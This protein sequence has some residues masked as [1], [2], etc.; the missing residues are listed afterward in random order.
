ML[1]QALV[2]ELKSAPLLRSD[3]G[4]ASATTL[5]RLQSHALPQDVVRGAM[6]TRC[7]SILRGHSAV[8]LEVIDALFTLVQRGMSPVI[9]LRGSISASG[10]L[11]PLAYVAGALQ[12]SPDVQVRCPFELGGQIVSAS[13]ALNLLDLKPITLGPKE[14]LG[15]VN[16]TAVSCAAGVLALHDAERLALLT[17]LLTAMAT[18]ALRGTAENHHPFIARVRPHTGQIECAAA[19]LAALDCSQMATHKDRTGEQGL[20]QDRYA[21]RTASQWIGPQLEDMELAHDQLAVEL[22]STT[23]NPL[24]DVGSDTIHHGGNF[25][26]ASVTSAMEKTRI[27]LQMLGKLMFAQASECINTTLNGTLPPNLCFG[28]PSLSF[29]FKGCDINMAAYM[30]ELA[31]LANPVS[32]HVQSAEMHN[33]AVNSLALISARFTS[34]AVEVTSLMA[35]THLYVLCQALDLQ[36]L[37]IEFTASIQH[38][39]AAL[40][41]KRF[42]SI[43]PDQIHRSLA[44]DQFISRILTNF[45]RFKN[46]DLED[47][48]A[49]STDDAQAHLFRSGLTKGF[50]LTSEAAFIVVVRDLQRT[51]VRLMMDTYIHLRNQVASM[52]SRMT[53]RLLGKGTAKMYQYVRYALGVPVYRGLY[54]DPTHSGEADGETVVPKQQQ[55]LIG[56]RV[57]VIYEDIRS[58]KLFDVL[59]DCMAIPDGSSGGFVESM[60]VSS[61]L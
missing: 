44:I 59:A 27:S 40:C 13:E 16:G 14:G 32:N 17:E 20:Y 21:L 55:A 36:A 56:S 24:V 45:T 22:N 30:S 57:A 52:E 5:S 10:D 42:H 37:H 54:G 12:G 25:Q 33:Q 1:Q 58:G 49:Q 23:D 15:L 19:I 51:I 7:N 28:D 53:L 9:P 18:E 43:I 41:K 6:L 50:P 11:M 29:A 39:V 34:D 46:S 2:Y 48:C 61:K 35:A 26:A 4:Q 8:R 47:R 3:R 60:M 31:Y 38:Q